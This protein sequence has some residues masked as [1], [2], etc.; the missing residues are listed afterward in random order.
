[1]HRGR[2]FGPDST[3][4]IVALGAWASPVGEVA[5]VTLKRGPPRTSPTR[6]PTPAEGD[7]RY[8]ALQRDEGQ[9]A[10][11]RARDSLGLGS[12]PGVSF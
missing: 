2:R 12:P 3:Q 8:E 11:R 10:P 6:S 4:K 9:I 7:R 1:M 5:H